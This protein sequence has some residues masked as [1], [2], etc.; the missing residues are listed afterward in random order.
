M[1]VSC[2]NTLE[3][4]RILREQFPFQNIHELPPVV[5]LHQVYHLCPDRTQVDRDLDALKRENKV[6]IFKLF[7]CGHNDFG[8]CLVSDL[9]YCI[10]HME[11]RLFAHINKKEALSNDATGPSCSKSEESSVDGSNSISNGSDGTSFGELTLAATRVYKKVLQSFLQLLPSQIN[12]SIDQGRLLEKIYNPAFKT[13]GVSSQQAVNFLIKRGLL[14][15]HGGNK[16]AYWFSIPNAGPLL[17][18]ISQGRTEIVTLF[19]RTKYKEMLLSKL[20]LCKLKNSPCAMAFHVQ[21]MI[22][23]GLL[24]KVATTSGLLLQLPKSVETE[25]QQ[26]AKRRR[27]SGHR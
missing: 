15:G 26:A 2:D 4:L 10:E 20:L 7:A 27:L 14:V 22:G 24:T 12:V 23:G 8:I 6:R 21:E 19:K 9:T 5:L 17:D 3:A 18:F 1:E 11:Q 16:E 25:H 13:D